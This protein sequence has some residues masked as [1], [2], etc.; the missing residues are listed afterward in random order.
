MLSVVVNQAGH[1]DY[2]AELLDDA[3]I[4]TS[5]DRGFSYK[6]LLCIAFDLALLRAHLDD[7]FPRF[8]FHDGVFES[9][10]DRKK[11]ALLTVIQRYTTLGIQSIVTL[12][13]SDMPPR[14]PADPV[15][16]ESEIVVLLHDEG[17]NGRLFKMKPW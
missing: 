8:A 16:G 10:D 3:G 17:D 2:R 1:L 12:I 13:D 11:E 15:F 6:K 9:L 7:A 5:A 4:A 14:L